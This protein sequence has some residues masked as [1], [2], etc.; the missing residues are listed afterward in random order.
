LE[1]WLEW[2]RTIQEV[3]IGYAA[4]L[5]DPVAAAYPVFDRGVAKRA[6]ESPPTVRAT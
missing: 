5:G 4:P 1:I 2:C 6:T 3:R